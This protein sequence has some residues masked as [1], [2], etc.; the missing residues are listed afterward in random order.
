[1]DTAELHHKKYH[2]PLSGCLGG[3]EIK[4]GTLSCLGKLQG[5]GFKKKNKIYIRNP[6]SPC[7][8]TVCKSPPCTSPFECSFLEFWENEILLFCF[9]KQQGYVV[10]LLG[11]RSKRWL[12]LMLRYRPLAAGGRQSVESIKSL[13]VI[14]HRNFLYCTVKGSIRI[15]GELRGAEPLHKKQEPLRMF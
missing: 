2:V 4:R 11:E 9:R 10:G 12:G 8:G 7:G 3:L 5:W 1:M 6:R 14:K 13:K 15:M